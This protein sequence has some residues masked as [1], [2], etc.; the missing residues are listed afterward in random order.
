[1][2]NGLE[3]SLLDHRPIS[4]QDTVNDSLEHF[5]DI[6]LEGEMLIS[7]TII[8]ITITIITITHTLRTIIDITFLHAAIR[9]EALSSTLLKCIV[10]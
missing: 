6:L 8:T 9:L 2:Y 5:H 10:V 7:T 3:L 4:V 1:M